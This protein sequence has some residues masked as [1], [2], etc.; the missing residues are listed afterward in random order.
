MNVVMKDLEEEIS[1][2]RKKIYVTGRNFLSQ[3]EISGHKKNNPFAGRKF[4]SQEQNFCHR[5]KF[6]VTV[7]KIYRKHLF[8]LYIINQ[9]T[10]L[11]RTLQ[12]CHAKTKYSHPETHLNYIKSEFT[13]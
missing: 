7:G 10:I 12:I 13:I 3:E 5:N 8:L 2:H 4:L 9:L 11:K 1:G 6:P